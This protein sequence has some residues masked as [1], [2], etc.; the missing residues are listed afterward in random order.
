MSSSS[1]D[2]KSQQTESQECH[3]RKGHPEQ[4]VDHMDIDK[5]DNKKIKMVGKSASLPAPSKSNWNEP[6]KVGW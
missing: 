3:K 5:I 2:L 6:G 1:N 4:P